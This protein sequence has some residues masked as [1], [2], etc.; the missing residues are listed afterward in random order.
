MM[1]IGILIIALLYCTTVAFAQQ[2]LK[3]MTYNLT[4]GVADKKEDVLKLQTW[5][6]SKGT[7][8]TAFQNLTG[9]DE[10]SLKKWLKNGNIN[11]LHY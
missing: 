10:K 3:V 11:I 9:T 5:M 1:R 8:V 2:T 6:K 4:D 7:D